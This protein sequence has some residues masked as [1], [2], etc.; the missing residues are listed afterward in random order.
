M[1]KTRMFNG[2]KYYRADEG[3]TDWMKTLAVGFRKI[4]VKS[5]V[6]PDIKIRGDS[7]LYISK[8]PAQFRGIK[9]APAW[10]VNPFPKWKDPKI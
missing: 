6:I 5:R 10:N 9:G 7:I 3:S 1:L 2:Y 4:N 8:N